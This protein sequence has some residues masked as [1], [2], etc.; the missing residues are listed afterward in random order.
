MGAK[1][2]AAAA[3]ENDATATNDATSAPAPLLKFGV[4]LQGLSGSG[5]SAVQTAAALPLGRV[6]HVDE[7]FLTSPPIYSTEWDSPNHPDNGGGGL[8]SKA[9]RAVWSYGGRSV[10][11]HSEHWESGRTVAIARGQSSTVAD[12]LPCSL[13]CNLHVF[14][15]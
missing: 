8:W 10:N 6:L 4:I 15:D 7:R 2:S 14:P 11:C 13:C 5:V 12:Q 1:Q 3:K 9:E